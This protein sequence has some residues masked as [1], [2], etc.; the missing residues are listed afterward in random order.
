MRSSF[1]LAG[2]AVVATTGA[3]LVLAPPSGSRAGGGVALVASET[4]LE[5]GTAAPSAMLVVDVEGTVRRPRIVRLPAGSRVADALRAAGG[6]APTADV[7]AAG[8]QLNLAA[9][10]VDGGQ[11]VVPRLGAPASAGSGPAGAGSAGGLMDLNRA[12]HGAA[13]HVAG[14]R[15]GDGPEDRGRANGA[16]FASLDETVERSV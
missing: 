3:W 4:P 7:A 8:A 2:S 16:P 12:A 11:V 9:P 6:Y 5:V 10:L 14:H 13:R 15:P 1:L